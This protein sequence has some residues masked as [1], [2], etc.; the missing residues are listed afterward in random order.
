[1][2]GVIG[3]IPSDRLERTLSNGKTTTPS[4]SS[5]F[6]MGTKYLLTNIFIGNV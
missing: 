4:T 3:S 2:D 5:D 1:M 6:H